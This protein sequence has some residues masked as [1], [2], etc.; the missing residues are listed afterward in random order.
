MVAALIERGLGYLSDELVVLGADGSTMD[1]YQRPLALRPGVLKALP[2]WRAMG[3][4][5]LDGPTESVVLVDPEQVVP[6]SSGQPCAPTLVVAPRY[7]PANSASLTALTASEGMVE[8]VGNSVRY[9]LP[10]PAHVGV[11]AELARRCRCFRLEF[12]DL[13]RASGM[14]VDLVG[15]P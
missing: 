1:G 14:L 15:G 7:S 2:R 13:A 9:G 8:L 3:G 4:A 6:G 11:L 12:G 5:D 10:D